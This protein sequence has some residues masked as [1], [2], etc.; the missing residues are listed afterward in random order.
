[1]MMMMLCSFERVFSVPGEAAMLNTTLVAMDVFS[2][3]TE[4]YNVTWY[5]PRT[6]QELSN[7]TGRVVVWGETLWL[8]SVQLEDAGKYESIV[9]TPSR[10]YRQQTHLVVE[11]PPAGQCGRPR[12]AG[13]S[14]SI[15]LNGFLSC[16]LKDYIRKLKDYNA[17]Y[18]MK[19]YKVRDHQ[20]SRGMCS[21]NFIA[22]TPNTFWSG[23]ELIEDRR[24]SGNYTCTLTFDLGGVTA[25]VSETISTT[26]KENYYMRPIV[27][28]PENIIIKVEKGSRFNQSCLVFVPCV[29]APLISISWVDKN[30]FIDS[31]PENRVYTVDGRSWRQESPS[32]G[33]WKEVLLVFS[34][35]REEDFYKNYTCMVFSARGIPQGFF[36]LLPADP[37][38]ALPIGLVLGSATVLFIT[39]IFLCY[40]FKVDIVL[41][42]RRTFPV[43]YTNTGTHEK[44]PTVMSLPCIAQHTQSLSYTHTQI[45]LYRKHA[46]KHTHTHTLSGSSHLI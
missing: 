3:T 21:P 36:T 26:I 17:S 32:R 2:F 31:E 37:Q 9:R 45:R 11:K 40:L 12:Q 25:S 5:D 27:H 10:C 46:H 35:V 42:F 33:L 44:N 20:K 38:I 13:Q 1:M 22:L 24:G 43:L 6:G 15:S 16:P 18:S 19:W 23:C 28:K 8:L 34:E 29:G 39:S 4:P 7:Q 14:L 30:D 41:C